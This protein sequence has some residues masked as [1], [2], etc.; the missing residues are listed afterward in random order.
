MA[1]DEWDQVKSSAAE[2]HSTQTQLNELA[3][4]GGGGVPDLAASPAAKKS[5]AKAIVEYLEPGVG[6]GGRHA[7]ESTAA[8]AKELGARDGHGWDSSGALK[9]AQRTWEKQVKVL[10]D[11]LAS[12]KHALSSAGVDFRNNDIGIGTQIVGRSRISDL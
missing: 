4:T 7:A 3:P 9:K 5:A 12:E 11:R 10:L 2:Q 1:W 6:S 8:A